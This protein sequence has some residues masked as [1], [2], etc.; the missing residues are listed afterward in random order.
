MNSEK[1]HHGFSKK[2]MVLAV[3]AAF[4]PAYGAEGDD[5]AQLTKP[6]SSAGIGLSYA[7]GNSNE[8]SIFGQYNGMR[9]GNYYG[10]LDID[11]VKRD[12]ATGTWT[13]L[14][15]RNL[16]LDDRDLSFSQQKQGDWKYYAEYSQLSRYYPRTINTGMLGAGSTNPTV[17]LLL[18]PGTGTELNLATK[19]EGVGLGMEKWLT[20]SLQFEANIKNE[21][22]EGARLFGKGFAC[23]AAWVT[24]GVCSASTTQ[25]A[26]LMLPEPINSNIRQL[27]A[28]LNFSRDKLLLTGGYYGSFYTN[29]YGNLTPN[30][31]GTLN[32]PLGTPTV[33]DAGLRNTLGLPMALPPD[34]QAHQLYLDG[35]YA[36]TPKTR[37]TFKYAYT[38]ATQTDNFLG[39]GLTGAPA[40]KADYGGVVD[41][42]LLQLGLTTHPMQKLSVLANLRYENRKDK[43]PQALYS[44]DGTEV[45]ANSKYSL[46]KIA[47]KLEGSYQLPDNYRATLGTDYEMLDRGDFSSPGCGAIDPITGECTGS[48]IAG[49]TAVRAKTEEIGWRAELQRSISETLTGSVSYASSRRDGAS[50]WLKPNSLPA[51]GTTELSDTQIY[52]RTGIFPMIFEN[53][54]RDKVKL[55]A[56]WSATERLSLQF[57]VEDAQD[58]YGAPTQKGLRD[59]GSLL[60]SIDAALTLSEAWKLTGYWSQGD[61]D[62]RVAHSTGYDAVLRNLN[63]TLGIG[64]AGKLSGRL[65]VGADLS[66]LNDSTKYN[67]TLDGSA[68]AANK[69]FLAQQGGLPEVSYDE[70]RLK[71]FGKYALEKNADLRVDLVHFRAR[72]DEWTWGY[73]GTPFT[74]S[75]NTIVSFDPKQHVTYV[76]ATYIYKWR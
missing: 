60:Y 16:G 32:N 58:S 74:Y 38:H 54:I 13:I 52:N 8:K 51:T 12:D 27:E 75:D 59:S 65:A 35:N 72:L 39:N 49:V 2:V 48:S 61:Q 6:E 40:G 21:D 57:I 17:V 62:I 68:S 10:Q 45:F 50:N 3:L 14:T 1:Q 44:V 24:A 73:G 47:G 7:S 66:Y 67:E 23:S 70:F 9:H 29:A 41:T 42:T 30:V 5:I 15:G 18:A 11:A 25:W 34:N 33:L 76:A 71:L 43:T 53:R 31:P 37:M 28:K 22:K 46:K 4:N 55:M 69:T 20:P 56:D 36:F 19:R 26:L 64:V 63:T